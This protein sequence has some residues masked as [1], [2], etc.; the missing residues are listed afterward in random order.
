VIEDCSFLKKRTKKLLSLW[1]VDVPTGRFKNKSFLLLFF[2]KEDSFFLCYL[3]H[4][5]YGAGAPAPPP[6]LLARFSA[7][8]GVDLGAESDLDDFWGFPAHNVL[9]IYSCMSAPAGAIDHV[10]VQLNPNPRSTDN[11]TT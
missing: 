10:R 6:T 11:N 3:W 7:S 4:G 5:Q 9:Q 8:V 2:K 1:S